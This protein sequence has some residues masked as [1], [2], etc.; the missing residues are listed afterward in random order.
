MKNSGIGKIGG[1]HAQMINVEINIAAT[2]Q[3]N[4]KNVANGFVPYALSQYKDYMLKVG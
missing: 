3:N 1:K 4:V 2:T